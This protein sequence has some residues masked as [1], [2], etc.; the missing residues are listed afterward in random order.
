MFP[1]E[2]FSKFRQVYQTYGHPPWT[3]GLLGDRNADMGRHTFVDDQ[4]FWLF[5]TFERWSACL[6]TLD[7]MVYVVDGRGYST[8]RVYGLACRDA[9][10]HN[11]YL[12][13]THLRC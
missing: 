12:Q 10:R 7:E 1:S 13:A 6:D 2:V 11:G 8:P 5:P 3:L 4:N 9:Q